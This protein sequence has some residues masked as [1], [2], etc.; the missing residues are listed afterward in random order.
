MELTIDQQTMLREAVA[1]WR[2]GK[3]SSF[4][5]MMAVVMIIDDTLLQPADA[6]SRAWAVQILKSRSKD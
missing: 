3:L 2:A 6:A 4:A 1:D 5:A